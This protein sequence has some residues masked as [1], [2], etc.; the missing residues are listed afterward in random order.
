[1]DLEALGFVGVV[2]GTQEVEYDIRRTETGCCL[3]RESGWYRA[4][5]AKRMKHGSGTGPCMCLVPDM[6]M[7]QAVVEAAWRGEILLL[8]ARVRCPC[9]G[10]R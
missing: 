9:Y 2:V 4:A 1:V 5:A 7:V 3:R 8:V 6:G 10:C